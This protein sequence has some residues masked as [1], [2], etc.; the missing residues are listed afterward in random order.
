[1]RTASYSA[2]SENARAILARCEVQ[3][4]A[5]FYTLR[6]SQVD[7]LLA[8]ADAMRYRKPKHANGSRGRYFHAMLQRRAQRTFAGLVR[9]MGRARA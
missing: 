5:D 4:G 7:A 6:A 2:Q 3:T 8:E 1:M 9:H